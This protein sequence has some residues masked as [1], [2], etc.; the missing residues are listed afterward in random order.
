MGYNIQIFKKL[1]FVVVPCNVL[2]LI[3]T[4]SVVK[5]VPN[6]TDASPLY[7]RI[8]NFC[9]FARYF[10][11]FDFCLLNNLSDLHYSIISD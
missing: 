6:E 4:L 5:N 10:V 9:L 3:A 1:T 11:L 7:L 2:T 8:C